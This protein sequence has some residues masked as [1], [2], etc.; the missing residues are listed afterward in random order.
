M[1]VDVSSSDELQPNGRLALPKSLGRCPHH[2]SVD[3]VRT[4]NLVQIDGHF[5][6]IPGQHLSVGE[7]HVGAAVT[8]IVNLSV[9]GFAAHGL[10]KLSGLICIEATEHALPD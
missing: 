5:D 9:D 8:E 4:R 2:L 7:F 10:F 6:D 1:S 3:V